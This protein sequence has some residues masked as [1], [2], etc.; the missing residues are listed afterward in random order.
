MKTVHALLAS[1]VLCAPLAAE[2]TELP[3]GGKGTNSTSITSAGPAEIDWGARKFVFRD[4]VKVKSPDFDLN[5]QLL[6]AYLH[7]DTNT[8]ERLEASGRVKLA[9]KDQSGEGDSMTYTVD[10][11]RIVFSGNARVM[12]KDNTVSGDKITI[13]RTNN[14]MR[15]DGGTKLF[16]P[17]SGADLNGSGSRKSGSDTKP[18]AR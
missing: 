3:L 16:L 14:L 2:T 10:D 6:T 13:F 12:Q 18:A 9:Q 7:K 11:E 4:G 5:C 1:V 8:L 15:V 17:N